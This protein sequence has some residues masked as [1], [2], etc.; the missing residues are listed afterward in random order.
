MT[1]ICDKWNWTT[2]HAISKVL[3]TVNKGEDNME[4]YKW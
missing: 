3:H 4:T 2:V 1:L